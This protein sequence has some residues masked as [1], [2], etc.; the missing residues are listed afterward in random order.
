MS[1]RLDAAGVELVQ[2]AIAARDKSGATQR[3]DIL[4]HSM[5][6]FLLN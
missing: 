1:A 2:E 6:A 3:G 5:V 4:D